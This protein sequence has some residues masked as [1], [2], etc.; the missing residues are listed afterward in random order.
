MHHSAHTATA[1]HLTDGRALVYCAQGVDDNGEA[2]KLGVCADVSSFFYGIA[3]TQH[4]M[5]HYLAVREASPRELAQAL[6]D[7]TARNPLMM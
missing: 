4:P 5:G 2:I 3:F 7:W 1:S 6:T